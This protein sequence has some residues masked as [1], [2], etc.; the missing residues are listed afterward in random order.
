[1]YPGLRPSPSC[2]RLVPMNPGSPRGRQSP[3]RCGGPRGLS[4]AGLRQVSPSL[5]SGGMFHLQLLQVRP[6][7]QRSGPAGPRPQPLALGTS[8]PHCDWDGCLAELVLLFWPLALVKGQPV[9]T[10]CTHPSGEFDGRGHSCHLT[11]VTPK[12]EGQGFGPFSSKGA[13]LLLPRSPQQLPS[14]A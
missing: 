9:D 13:L 8:P 3:Q 14:S 10:I 2:P 6:P 5:P 11:R 4:A 12:R 1:M 7:C